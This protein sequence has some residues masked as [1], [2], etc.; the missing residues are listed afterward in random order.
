MVEK[1]MCLHRIEANQRKIKFEAVYD[2]QL[3]EGLDTIISD[4]Q[5]IMQVLLGL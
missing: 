1:V 3:E 2:D 5:R 4:E